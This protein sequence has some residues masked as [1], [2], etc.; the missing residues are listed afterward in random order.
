MTPSCA[1]PTDRLRTSS[2]RG[3]LPPD[4]ASVALSFS[5]VRVA[6]PAERRRNPL[7]RAR[8]VDRARAEFLELPG[9]YL[10]LPQAQRLF[11]LRRDICQ[12]VLETLVHEG[13]LHA[14]DP[15]V[16]TRTRCV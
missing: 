16:Y 1:P 13:F 8:L 11:G 4:A 3:L 14:P 2:V 10:T 7:W 5:A 15:G 12:R 6:H 9:M